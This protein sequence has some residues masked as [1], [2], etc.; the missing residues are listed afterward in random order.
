VMNIPFRNNKLAW[1][2]LATGANLLFSGHALASQN[3]TVS[4]GSSGQACANAAAFS[5]NASGQMP[6]FLRLQA[7]RSQCSDVS[8]TVTRPS[9]A[10]IQT[11]FLAPNSSQP[12]NLG[13]LASG[14][15]WFLISATGRPGGCNTGS[16]SR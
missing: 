14:Q 13:R 3:L 9:G 12:I 6:V 1:L 10:L 2:S 15:H 5:V 8:Y 11:I 16:L 7:P 4:C